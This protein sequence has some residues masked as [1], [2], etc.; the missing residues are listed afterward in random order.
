[1]AVQRALAELDIAPGELDEDQYSVTVLRPAQEGFL[2]VGGV[3]AVVEVRLLV[4]GVGSPSP[5][6]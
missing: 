3:D 4:D 1:M 2:S 5:R 6:G